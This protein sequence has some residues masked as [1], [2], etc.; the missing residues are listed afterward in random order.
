MTGTPDPAVHTLDAERR[1]QV[2]VR[3]QATLVD[4]IDLTLQ[5][6]QAHW[7]VTGENSR[8]VNEQLDE[9]V[10]TYREWADSIA[11]RIA[12]LGVNPDGRAATVAAG[13]TVVPMPLGYLDD[14]DV[15]TMFVERLAATAAAARS[16]MDDL[17][18]LDAV[19]QDILIDVVK[20]LEEDLWMLQAQHR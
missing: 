2:A 5:A 7:N 10:D 16:L 3:L 1:T 12:A 9:I 17:G 15:V 14:A 11:E 20:D 19:S 8:T 6:K 18:H 13:S 4:L